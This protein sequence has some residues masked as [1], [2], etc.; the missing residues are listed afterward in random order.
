MRRADRTTALKHAPGREHGQVTR[1]NQHSSRSGLRLWA[2]R[3]S[4]TTMQ[5]FALWI[6]ALVVFALGLSSVVRPLLPVVAGQNFSMQQNN[7]SVSTPPHAIFRA[8]GMS[9]TD[10]QWHNAVQSAFEARASSG[11]YLGGTQADTIVI[12]TQSMHTVLDPIA[13]QEVIKELGLTTDSDVLYQQWFAQASPKERQTAQLSQG[14]VSYKQQIAQEQLEKNIASRLAALP[15]LS[16]G[17][18]YLYYQQHLAQFARTAPQMHLQQIVVTSPQMAQQVVD[19]L[20]QGIPFSTVEATYDVSGPF[21]RAHGG[22]LGWISVG[23]SGEP[24]EWGANVLLLKAGQVGVP[25]QV[26]GRYYIVKCIEGPD[27]QPWSFSQVQDQV[28][29]DLMLEQLNDTFTHILLQ[30]EK[31]MCIVLLDPQYGVPLQQFEAVLG[32]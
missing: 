6:I 8:D 4:R 28:R 10:T 15:S 23:G 12:N 24:P 19:Q 21:Y 16:A 5:L 29:R 18:V 11:Q 2:K 7:G 20:H 14:N 26:S 1:A 32:N 9:I 13:E 17:D 3:N 27:Y 30:K 31:K 25:F 22:D